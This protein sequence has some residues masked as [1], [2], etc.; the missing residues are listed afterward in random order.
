MSNQELDEL[1]VKGKKEKEERPSSKLWTILGRRLPRN[2]IVFFCQI[3]LIYGVTIVALISLSRG[4]EP[5]NLW[6]ALLTSC[7]GYVLPNPT[8][9][10]PPP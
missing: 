6:V 1:R 9:S 3:I 4:S 7:L 5:V 10:P 8:I 2:E